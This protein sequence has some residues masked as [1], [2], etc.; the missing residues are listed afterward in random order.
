MSERG[1]FECACV[2]SSLIVEFE[3]SDVSRARLSL[4]ALV[5]LG[6]PLLGVINSRALSL[7]VVI[8]ELRA[9]PNDGFSTFRGNL[10][11]GVQI[12]RA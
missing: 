3:F 7:V 1:C 2:R 10:C 9:H 12:W 11:F 6:T 8:V 5:E 4:V